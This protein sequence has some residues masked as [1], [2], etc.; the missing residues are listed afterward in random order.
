MRIVLEAEVP[1]ETR[2]RV[3]AE[4]DH[5]VDGGTQARFGPAGIDREGLSGEQFH[6]VE[7]IFVCHPSMYASVSNTD[8]RRDGLTDVGVSQQNPIEFRYAF[9]HQLGV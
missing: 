3:V 7:R 1:L 4:V 2:T 8:I 6:T 9:F 5:G